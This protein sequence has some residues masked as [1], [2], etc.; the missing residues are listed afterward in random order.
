MRGHVFVEAEWTSPMCHNLYR[1]FLLLHE[2]W[3]G[4]F[5]A[6]QV[7]LIS[8]QNYFLFSQQKSISLLYTFLLQAHAQLVLQ[9]EILSLIISRCFN[10]TCENLKLSETL[11]SGEK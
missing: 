5:P 11:I 2:N 4:H 6:G 9:A 8:G 10:Y 7:P 3:L 1:L